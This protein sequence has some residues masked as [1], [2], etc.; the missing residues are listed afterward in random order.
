MPKRVVVV[1]AR[2][3]PFDAEAQG[4]ELERVQSAAGRNGAQCQVPA[5][6]ADPVARP[7]ERREL[8]ERERRIGE[9][10]LRRPRPQRLHQ[11]RIGKVR[12]RQSEW[13]DLAPAAH[14]PRDRT[15]HLLARLEQDEAARIAARGR[16]GELR[17]FVERLG[18]VV[19]RRL[20]GTVEPR[21]PADGLHGHGKGW[22]S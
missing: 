17:G 2:A 7:Q 20:V 8:D 11:R 15:A 14:G 22:G 6:P 13:L 1:E 19:E 5:V 21:R 16:L 9:E 18:G 10:A 4:V 12:L 3:Q